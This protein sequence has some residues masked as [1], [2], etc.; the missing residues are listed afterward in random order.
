MAA[1]RPVLREQLTVCSPSWNVL[2]L[3]R[4]TRVLARTATLHS[5]SL[6]GKQLSNQDQK[7]P[8][9]SDQRDGPALRREHLLLQRTWLGSSSRN[10]RLPLVSVAPVYAIRNLHT[11]KSDKH[12]NLFLSLINESPRK[13]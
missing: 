5:D 11:H 2:H 12:T 9:D 4:I 7:V 3:Q 10:L 1:P 13:C 8:C 6:E